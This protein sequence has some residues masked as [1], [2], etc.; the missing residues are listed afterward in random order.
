MGFLALGVITGICAVGWFFSRLSTKII[1]CF[2]KEKGYALPT[3]AE[4][5]VCSRKVVKS[6]FTLGRRNRR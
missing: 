1:L 2:I 5:K 4:L 3:D 6:L